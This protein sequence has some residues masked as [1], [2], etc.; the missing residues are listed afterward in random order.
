MDTYLEKELATVER[1]A[2]LTGLPFE[3][4]HTG[5]GCS[6][7]VLLEDGFYLMI[8][9]EGASIPDEDSE[10]ITVGVYLGDD[11]EAVHYE[12]ADSISE[13][14]AW[15]KVRSNWEHFIGQVSA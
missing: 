11:T 7:A 14:C 13:A 10:G 15:V 4:E 1:I 6:A 9:D 5:G 3:W 8:T 12:Y 2:S